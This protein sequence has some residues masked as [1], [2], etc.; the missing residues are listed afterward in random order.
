MKSFY[1]FIFLTECFFIVVYVYFS[2]HILFLHHIIVAAISLSHS[3]DLKQKIS[4]TLKKLQNN[5][6][7]QNIKFWTKLYYRLF[8]L[9]FFRFNKMF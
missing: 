1:N 6:I 7:D 9:I 3:R 5:K 2:F 4:E 8:I